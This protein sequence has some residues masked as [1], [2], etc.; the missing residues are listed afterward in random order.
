MMAVWLHHHNEQPLC[1]LKKDNLLFQ[2]VNRKGSIG[3]NDDFITKNHRGTLQG[4]TAGPVEVQDNPKQV[5]VQKSY[6][7]NLNPNAELTAPA[8]SSQH[9]S[10]AL[11]ATSGM[12]IALSL[13]VMMKLL[14][15]FACLSQ[16]YTNH[17]V[18]ATGIVHLKEIGAQDTPSR[19]IVPV[20][21][22]KEH[23]CPLSW[24][25]HTEIYVRFA[26]TKLTTPTPLLCWKATRTG[27]TFT[28]H[29]LLGSITWRSAKANWV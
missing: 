19:S 12:F 10:L 13:A 17:W 24:L 23:L 29:G 6:L 21:P 27:W 22:S 9:V 2:T 28:T 5:A 7:F 26:P 15:S 4:T 20:I 18:Q 3:L 25:G 11:T 14:S 16:I 1:Q 8:R